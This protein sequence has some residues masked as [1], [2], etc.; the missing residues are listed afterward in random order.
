MN[1]IKAFLFFCM[2]ALFVQMPVYAQVTDSTNLSF[3]FGNFTNWV[4]YTWRYSTDASSVNTSKV[5]GIVSRR[6]TIMSD[7]SAYDAN[8]GYALKKIPSGY[9]YSARLGDEII[10]SDKNPRCWEQSLRYTM[11]I[12]SSNALLIMKF[13]C[14]L[15]YASDHTA[16]ME[17]R[18]RLTLYDK[19]G[20]TIPDCSNYDVY[21]SSSYV[22][23]FNTYTPSG[24]TTPVKWRDWTTVGA[25]LLK[26]IGQT[27]TIEFMSAD[28]TGKYHYGYAYFVAES[29]PLYIT[30]KYCAGDSVASLTAPEGFEK[31]SW[32]NN[33]GKVVDSVQILK[34]IRPLEGDS[35]TCTMTSATGC[36]VTLQSTIAKYAPIADFSSY[37]LDCKSNTV[38]FVNLSTSTHGTM[39]YKW[40]FGD[41]ISSTQKNP[42]HTFAISG[43]HPMCLTV[44]NPPSTCADTL[45]KVVESFSP[46]LVGIAGDST[47]CPN[48][49][50]YLKAF[51]AY[52]YLWNTG[53]V[54]DS[55]EVKSPGGTFWMIGYSST[56]CHSDT[57]YRMVGEEPDWEF[58]S[59]SDTTLCEGDSTVLLVSGAAHYLWNT[60]D[61]TNTITVGAPGEYYV[62]G[63]NKRGCKKYQ[64]YNVLE[65]P[66]PDVSLTLSTYTLNSKHNQLNGS[67]PAQTDVN[68][69]WNL[70]DGTTQTGSVF[71]HTYN[72]SNEMLQYTITAK[73]TSIYDCADS[74]T[75]IID[76]V[77]FV[78]NV[79]S[80]NE[81]GINDVFMSGLDLTVFDRNGLTVY[82]GTTGWNGKYNGH[83]IDPDTYFYLIRYPSRNQQMQTIKGYITVVR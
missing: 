75:T 50:V 18:F 41:S 23:G 17:P 64:N 21:S 20:N 72:I 74:V 61:T 69:L 8:T 66:I 55:I 14:V 34:V 22:K 58:L 76:V 63:Y 9:L 13:A 53:S 33:S 35:Y 32:A 39:Q 51:G 36:V 65:Y 71:Q 54:A 78:P 57:I 29:H 40:D 10:S 82:Q 1:Q 43:L 80:P 26:Y 83:L 48:L 49:S 45:K 77:P 67:L 12:D 70:G 52:K 56:G 5:K 42:R 46:P 24:S 30:V 16:L 73:A 15:Q 47:Y 28:C 68:Y 31:Y 27:M 81:D 44:K 79:F 38:Q 60:N 3:Q 59:A 2:I 25:D 4:G 6:Q 37:M 7:T 11:T 19:S 62:I